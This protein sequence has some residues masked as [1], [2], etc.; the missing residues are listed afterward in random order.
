MLIPQGGEAMVSRYEEILAGDVRLVVKRRLVRHRFLP[1]L[2]PERLRGLI[3]RPP[4]SQRPAMH[5][6][7]RQLPGSA[8]IIP[9]RALPV[10]ALA[11]P[12]IEGDVTH[13]TVGVTDQD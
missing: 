9:G 2:M 7:V 6:Q 4:C 3:Q 5:L 8:R 12:V 1:V 11:T 13:G 10:I